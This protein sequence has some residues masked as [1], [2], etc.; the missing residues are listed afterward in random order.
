MPGS[1]EVSFATSNEHKFSEAALVLGRIGVTLSRLPSKGE[2]VQSDNP[3]EI[4]AIAAERTFA[5]AERPVIVEDTALFVKSLGGFPGTYAAYVYRTLG[6]E[7]VL[8]L[9]PQAG[10]QAEFVSAVAYCDGPG[11]AK[12]FTGRLAGTIATAQR[13]ANGFGYDPIFVPSGDSRTLGEMTLDEKCSI[14]HRGKAVAAFGE[15]YLSA[16]H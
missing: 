14:S 2:E 4:A 5:R 7:L 11:R 10:R 12:V 15:W 1:S 6:L 9:V 16:R 8:K 3:S 13:G